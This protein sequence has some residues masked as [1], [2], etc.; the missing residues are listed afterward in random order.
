MRLPQGQSTQYAMMV[1]RTATSHRTTNNELITSLTQPGK[2]V[3]DAEPESLA[4]LRMKL[5]SED[6]VL[7]DHR[8]ERS[9]IVVFRSDDDRVFENRIVRASEID[10]GLI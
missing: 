8:R 5:S 10:R 1:P 3:K 4:L 7:P 6:V 9:S 2:A